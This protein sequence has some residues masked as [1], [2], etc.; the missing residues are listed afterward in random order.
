MKLSSTASYKSFFENKLF[1]GDKLLL[2]TVLYIGARHPGRI[3][4]HPGRIMR[5]P[6]GQARHLG[7]LLRVDF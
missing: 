2:Y 4:R 6:G 7:G 1:S 5:H 3:M